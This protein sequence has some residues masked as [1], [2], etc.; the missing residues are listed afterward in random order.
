[1]VMASYP[2]TK[3]P[4]Q[5]LWATEPFY[6]IHTEGLFGAPARVGELKIFTLSQPD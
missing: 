5:A 6:S 2:G 1:M 4:K 3:L